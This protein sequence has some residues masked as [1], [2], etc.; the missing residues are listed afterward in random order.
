MLSGSLNDID[1]NVGGDN[2]WFRHCELFR[3]NFSRCHRMIFDF[4]CPIH[5]DDCRGTGSA[6]CSFTPRD[7]FSFKYGIDK[8]NLCCSNF[9]K[10]LVKNTRGTLWKATSG[11]KDLDI[12]YDQFKNRSDLEIEAELFGLDIESY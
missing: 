2:R 12:L 10:I 8:F 6:A 1:Q 5:V 9:S 11:E 4:P 7:K 3:D